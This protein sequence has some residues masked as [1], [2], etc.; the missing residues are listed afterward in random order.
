[1]DAELQAPPTPVCLTEDHMTEQE[2]VVWVR[3]HDRHLQEITIAGNDGEKL[4]SDASG[5]PVF[6]LRR[7]MGWHVEDAS[8]NEIAALRH[9]KFFT[10]QHTAVDGK[11]LSSGALVEMRPRDA[12]GITNY[13]NIGNV[14]IAEISVHLNNVKKRFVRDRDISVFR[15][16]V[17]KGVDLSLVVLMSMIRA[18]MAH[19]WQK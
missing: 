6:D 18:E 4:F 15:V 16:R 1:M 10:P 14:T 9:K 8:G 5:R 13:V 3:V 7:K 12:M 19:V 2:C 17:A 11:I